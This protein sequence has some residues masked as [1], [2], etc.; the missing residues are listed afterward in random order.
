MLWS[1]DQEIMVLATG[2]FS[3]LYLSKFIDLIWKQ[4]LHPCT[5]KLNIH[6]MYLIFPGQE[7]LILMTRE[8]DPLMEFPMHP[9]AFG[10]GMIV[11]YVFYV[12]NA[13]CIKINPKHENC[14]G[15]VKELN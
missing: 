11:I 8:F 9:D 1:P 4:M 13:A 2:S 12:D 5:V 14:K 10:E 7:T 15:K 6:Q 3:S